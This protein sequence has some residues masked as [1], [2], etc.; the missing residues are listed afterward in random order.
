MQKKYF[1]ILFAFIQV[2]LLASDFFLNGQ[3]LINGYNNNKFFSSDFTYIPNISYS[4]NINNKLDFDISHSFSLNKSYNNYSDGNPFLSNK[5]RSWFRLSTNTLDLRIGLQKIAFGSAIFLRPLS[6]FDSLDFKSNTGQTYG[7]EALRLIMS[8]SNLLSIWFWGINN[9]GAKPSFGGR[10]EKSNIG[11]LSG[12]WGFTYYNDS[13][14]DKH[15]PYQVGQ[16]LINYIPDYELFGEDVLDID[17]ILG[18]RE[19]SR[20]G[21]DYRYDGFFGFWFESSYY[22]MKKYDDVL[23]NKF[24]F[25]TLGFD[26]TLPFLNGLLL[27]TETIFSEVD[28]SIDSESLDNNNYSSI[29]FL[30]L[31]IN[32][33]NDFSFFHLKD[34]D[35][36]IPENNILRWSTTYD[37]FSMNYMLTLIPGKLNDIFQ[38]EF[39][40]NH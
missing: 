14:S 5:Y 35:N 15:L 22:L 30:S 32:I 33:I 13:D 37:S 2:H 10:I 9:E 34:W 21:I 29:V 19:N 31:P 12:D 11:I 18:F 17:N 3:L 28:L 20:F 40:Y 8:P 36:N 27:T 1:L 23:F 4:Y 6:W 24:S 26:Y 38:I 7:V 16:F 25:L 39:I